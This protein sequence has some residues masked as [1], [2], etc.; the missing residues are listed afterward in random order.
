MSLPASVARCPG[1]TVSA[2]AQPVW[3]FPREHQ[4][5]LMECARRRQGIVDYMAGQQ[6]VWM[7][8]PLETPCPEILRAKR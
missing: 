6:V 2:E 4:D 3:P 8:A 5:C 7:R 1:Q